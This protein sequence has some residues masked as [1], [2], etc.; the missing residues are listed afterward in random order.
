MATETKPK[1]RVTSETSWISVSPCG[2][3]ETHRRWKDDRK[4]GDNTPL[5]GSIC[6][7]RV[8]LKDD[9][10]D[11]N[12]PLSLSETEPAV[13]DSSVQL[14][15]FPRSADAVLQVPLGRWV[16]LCMGEG[17]CDIVESCLEGMRTG[18]TCEVS[19]RLQLISISE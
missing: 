2:L 1:G 5:L 13:S 16:V 10:E 12:H 15:E 11:E 18:E 7:I 8:R 6:K 3:W 14:T 4:P 19:V 17:Q 9:A